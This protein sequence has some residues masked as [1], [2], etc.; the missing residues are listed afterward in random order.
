MRERLDT[1]EVWGVFE[2]S[3]MCAVIVGFRLGILKPHSAQYPFRYLVNTPQQ[4]GVNRK[5]LIIHLCLGVVGFDDCV[6][7]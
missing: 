4:V 2:I 3:S 7:A 1:P 6:I 5:C